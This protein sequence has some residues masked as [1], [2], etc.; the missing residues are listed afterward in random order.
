MVCL[1][2][3]SGGVDSVAMLEALAALARDS[4]GPA[5]SLRCLHVEHGIRP[6]EESR[7][8]AAFV[9]ELCGKHAIPCKIVSVEPGKIAGTAKRE[10]I[11]IEAAAR[12]YRRR[13]LFREARVIEAE[14]TRPVRILIAH[15]RD[16]MLETVLMRAFRG[17]GP[18]GLAAMP[19][20]RGRILR[21]LLTLSRTDTFHYLDEKNVPWREDSTNVDIRFLRNRIRY[22]L[23]PF[24]NESFPCWRRGFASLAETQALAAGFITGEARRRVRWTET[25]GRALHTDAET[26]F[27]QNAI[28]R[29][30]A[31]FR[32]LDRLLRGNESP[33]PIKRAGIR[34][35]CGGF[36]K[37]VDLGPV[38][39]WREDG[40]IM[41]SLRKNR[42]AERGFVLLIKMP[43]L[44]ILKRMVIEVKPFSGEPAGIAGGGY[45]LLPLALRRSFK[46][47]CIDGKHA[48]AESARR[49]RILSL[50]DQRGVAAFI[51]PGGVSLRRE[52]PKDIADEK[53]YMV[54]AKRSNNN[55]G[56]MDVQ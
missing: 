27:A 37:A 35:F 10:G 52:V 44:Y 32:G 48:P 31:L 49:E 46:G 3:V 33:V 43:G 45:A 51:G 28:I 7:G 22:H 20:G 9:G 56:G 50:V 34:R 40:R 24:L 47:D 14:G 5:F 26:F 6:P 23:I 54:K 16:D 41:L 2:A 1:A 8:D 17:S 30:E 36:T 53:L 12:L 29:E 21:P 19:A 25:G 39:I 55:T 11:G 15:T 42:A 13:A 18:A 4:T 38:R